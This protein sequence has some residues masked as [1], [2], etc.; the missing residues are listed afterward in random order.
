MKITIIPLIGAF[1]FALIFVNVNQIQVYDNK[2]N[3]I[4]NEFDNFSSPLKS[5]TTPNSKPLTIFQHAVVSQ[6]FYPFSLPTNVSYTLV[7]G[8]TSKNTTINYEGVSYIKDRVNNGDFATDFSGWDFKNYS[9]NFTNNGWQAGGY[10]NI[11][12]LAA[13]KTAGDYG[14]F[15][16]NFTIQE[17]LTLNKLATIS[18][19]YYYDDMQVPD[20]ISLYLAIIN[21]G[22]EKNISVLFTNLVQDS[23]TTVTLIYNPG[24]FGHM[25]PGNVTV[26]A[27][28]FVNANTS[29]GGAAQYFSVDNVKFNIWTKP[30]QA[31]L[32]RAYD[33]EF[34]ANYTYSNSSNGIG[35]SF[36]DVERNLTG[37]DDVI[38]TISQNITGVDDFE[39]FNITISSYLMKNYN[40]T[41]YGASGSFYEIG[42]TIN[43]SI[44]C[45]FNQPF[46]YLENWIEIEKPSDW[47]ILHMYDGFLVDQ[48]ASCTGTGIGSNKIIIPKNSY[49]AGLWEIKG[50]SQNYIVEGSLGL[51][52]G[53]TFDN[54]SKVTMNDIFQL[55]VRLNDTISITNTQVNCTIK[56]PNSTIFWQGNQVPSDFN[57]SFGNFT[58][59]D[60]MTVGDYQVIV[61][62][63]NNQSYLDRDKVGY[64][65][66]NFKVWHHTELQAVDSYI[67]TLV[68]DPLLVKVNFTDIDFNSYIDFGTIT[69]NM[70]YGASGN[71]AYIGSGIYVI[72]LDTSGLSLGS[73][74]ISFNASKTFY[75]N[76]SIKDLI[77][78]DIIAQPLAL[79]VP[80]TVIHANAS[81]Y[82]V[83]NINTT[84]AISGSLEYTNNVTTN[85]HKWYN[86]TH[87]PNGTHTVNLSTSDTITTGIL[88]TFSIT[89]YANKTNYGSTS[90]IV[91]IM[92]H[93]IPTLAEVN[94]TIVEVVLN[95]LFYLEVN[96]TI[97]ETGQL[98][99]GANCSIT[100]DSTYNI[101]TLGDSFVVCFNTSGLSL[102]SYTAVIQ[103]NQTDYEIAFKIIYVIMKPA[104]SNLTII[105]PAPI[106]F[107]K[108]DIVNLSCSFLSGGQQILNSSITLL[109]DITGNF[110]WNGSAY[111]YT[112][113]TPLL[114]IRNYFVQIY[115]IGLNVETQYKDVIFEVLGMDIEIKTQDTTIEYK[116]GEDNSISIKVYD[117]SHGQFRTD[118]VVNYEI[119]GI[120]GQFV[121]GSNNSFILDIDNLN[122]LPRTQP[123]EL[124]I[125]ISNPYGDDAIIIVSIS[126]PVGEI[127]LFIIIIIFGVILAGIASVFLIKRRYI[128]MTKF[129]REIKSVKGQ[130]MKGK[131][132][133]VSKLT[134][135]DII[136][137]KLNLIMPKIKIL[138]E[139]RRERT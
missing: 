128:D 57:V 79:E 27:G 137:E 91:T 81:G 71:L 83:F 16:Q 98:I 21:N 90:D 60:N 103:L 42:A 52:N 47:N 108:G 88:E 129:Q 124:Q 36:I 7:D 10:M 30:N 11:G 44:Q 119:E 2:S 123:Y 19:D 87:Y 121:T 68:G 8:W 18:M 3:L 75:E 55:K 48:I 74:Y 33:V 100:W 76:Q 25:L 26:R 110:T 77:Q 122:L 5:S 28:I 15:E 93:P 1:L 104:P 73:Y 24:E 13:A 101:S 95:D 51:W 20:D 105:N 17:D 94:N 109:G 59:G 31:N 133:K 41:F 127:N 63:T 136:G 132:D 118:L 113:N 85:W 38:F 53:T 89:I 80:R 29:V 39:I 14:Y 43:W 92:V 65:E 4:Y 107:I 130:F 46:T 84:G 120:T 54:S 96:Y 12:I 70:S 58:V 23:W 50:I 35:T 138:K 61:E 131:F 134:R 135:D 125:T 139:D 111:I 117:N 66:F 126:V 6:S 102:E 45:F 64:V 115:A 112:V 67:E 56:Y 34:D 37:T 82:V 40:T 116:E 32:V 99:N 9:P 62:W 97:E 114:D 49:S 69:Y 72:D 78:L 22:L 106:K 86:I